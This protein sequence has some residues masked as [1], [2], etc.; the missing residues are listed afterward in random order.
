MILGIIIISVFGAVSVWNF[1]VAILGLFPKLHGTAV[2][3]LVKT[4]TARNVRVKY[5][6]IPILTNFTYVYTVNGHTYRYRGEKAKHKRYV[7]QKVHLVFVKWFP[8]HAYPNR[9]KGTG[10]WVLGIF[11][12][13]MAL[14]FTFVLVYV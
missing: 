14:T 5:G 8:R 12:L 9:F 13:F 11:G 2:G 4:D 10:E 6:T 1:T 7:P 3:K